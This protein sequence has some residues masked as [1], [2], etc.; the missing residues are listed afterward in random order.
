MKI[1]N[2]ANTLIFFYLPLNSWGNEP[3]MH[4]MKI[5]KTIFLILSATKA[6]ILEINKI[7]QNKKFIS[8][9]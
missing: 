3:K 7:I 8:I 6:K 2:I 1:K 4:Q 9:E 5:L